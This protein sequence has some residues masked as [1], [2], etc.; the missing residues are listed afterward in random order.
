MDANG[1][2]WADHQHTDASYTQPA[3]EPSFAFRSIGQEDASKVRRV[4]YGLP[5]SHCKAYYAADL[6]ACPYCGSADRVTA[7]ATPAVNVS[8]IISEPLP[9]QAATGEILPGS[10]EDDLEPSQIENRERIL[11]EYQKQILGN[12]PELAALS[13]SQCTLD[14]NHQ[15]G[16]SA[17]AAVCKNCYNEIAIQ[18]EQLEAALCIDVREAAQVIYEAVW[19]DPS[20]SDPSRT[21]QNAALALLNELRR[22]AGIAMPVGPVAPYAH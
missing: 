21:Y 7:S 8:A 22:R 4:G 12:N 19:A 2:H 15:T 1:S 6:N 18:L 20:P 10:E 16:T 11:R 17:P 9:V 13:Q 14:K 5:C 3:S